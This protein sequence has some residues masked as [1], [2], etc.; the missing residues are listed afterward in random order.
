MTPQEAKSRTDA[1]RTRALGSWLPYVWKWI[2]KR[3]DAGES[4]VSLVI[5]GD[6]VRRAIRD[7][8]RSLG[9]TAETGT[10]LGCCVF[11]RDENNF[12]NTLFV[13]WEDT[14]DWLSVED[15]R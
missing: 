11:Q 5:P 14:S 2:G 15:K 12:G 6:G 10:A 4:K 13:S 3:A 9:Y 1:G 8:L 7:Y